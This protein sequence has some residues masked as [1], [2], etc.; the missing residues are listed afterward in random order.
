MNFVFQIIYAG[1]TFS[2]I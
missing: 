2:F 1:S